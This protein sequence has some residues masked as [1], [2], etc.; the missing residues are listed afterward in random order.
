LCRRP[1]AGHPRQTSIYPRRQAKPRARHV[2]GRTIEAAPAT[3]S[4][5][6]EAHAWFLVLAFL[7]LPHQPT[8]NTDY[9]QRFVCATSQQMMAAA[10]CL[11][12]VFA[13]LFSFRMSG[14][15]DEKSSELGATQPH[16]L[17]YRRKPMEGG[18]EKWTWKTC[19]AP[20]RYPKMLDLRQG[21]WSVQCV[22]HMNHCETRERQEWVLSKVSNQAP[23]TDVLLFVHVCTY[24]LEDSD[25]SHRCAGAVFAGLRASWTHAR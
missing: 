4:T 9:T 24:M 18:N 8:G 21:Y 17:P 10:S 19:R 2:E 7:S 16:N 12:V 5:L 20:P 13:I 6:P 25:S 11:I 14:L 23:R 22:L 3:H 15:S 1:L